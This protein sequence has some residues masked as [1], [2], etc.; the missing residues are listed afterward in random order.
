MMAAALR[1]APSKDVFWSSSSEHYPLVPKGS[2][3]RYPL[4]R[5]HY[6]VLQTVVSHAHASDLDSE[7]TLCM[8]KLYGDYYEEWHIALNS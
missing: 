4:A 2:P 7:A 8:N 1:L 6:P 3:P 5:E